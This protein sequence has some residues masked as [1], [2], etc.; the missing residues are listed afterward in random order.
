MALEITHIFLNIS[1]YKIT[2]TT[3]REGQP[4]K[5]SSSQAD[6]KWELAICVTEVPRSQP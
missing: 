2:L 3:C 4:Q 6:D 5:E 1:D